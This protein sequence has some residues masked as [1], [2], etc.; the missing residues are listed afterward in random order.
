MG[1]E[2]TQQA[3]ATGASSLK[4]AEEKAA[5]PMAAE[6]KAADPMA[7]EEKA[8]DP[9][10][11]DPA[12][13]DPMAADPVAAEPVATSTPAAPDHSQ[14]IAKDAEAL[15]AYQKNAIVEMKK[16]WQKSKIAGE[17]NP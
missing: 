6:E 9:A 11:A 3:E 2:D 12:A 14:K 15:V 7:A 8:A 17:N 16:Q 5:D 4:A 1:E 10:A 13:A